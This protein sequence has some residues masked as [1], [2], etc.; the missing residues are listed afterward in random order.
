MYQDYGTG[1]ADPR[2]AGLDGYRATGSA[3]SL[4]SG[5]VAYTLRAGGSGGVDRH[6]LLLLAGGVA[7]GVSGVAQRRVLDGSCR[8]GD[9]AVDARGIR[10]VL[11]P[12]RP[13]ARR[14]LQV[15]CR[16]G[17]RHELERGRGRAGAGAALRCQAQGSH[18]A[19]RRSR[20]R[21]QP[22]WGKQWLDRPQRTLAAECDSP[23]TRQRSVSPARTSTR[24]RATE[25]ARRSAIPIEA[26]ALLATYGR[27]RPPERPLWLGSVKSNIGHTQAAA[28]VAGVI[29]MAM[30]MRHGVLPRTLHVD[31]PSS[32]VDWSAGAVS[33]LC[34]SA[35]WPGDRGPRRAAVSSFGVSGTNAHLILE[36]APAAECERGLLHRERQRLHRA[37]G[38]VRLRATTRSA[39]RPDVLRIA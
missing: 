26:Q 2:A 6:G 13:R 27:S 21:R 34:D 9:G 15:L 39:R 1:L 37:L 20:E 28:G 5:R 11:P 23:G 12:A 33:L 17:R 3:G 24:S 10:G 36:E 16:R 19:C 32:E 8:R 7:L 18:G 22:G 29:K 38:G 30:A 25:P 14:S 4:V 35:P 31:R